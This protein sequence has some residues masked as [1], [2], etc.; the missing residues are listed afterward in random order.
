MLASHLARCADCRAFEESV[1][2]FTQEIRSAPLQSPQQPIVVRRTR[3]VSLTA[4]QIGVAATLAIAVL[5]VVSQ[6]RVPESPSPAADGRP[7]TTNLFK[8]SWQP[9]RELAQID[10]AV[11]APGT[12]RPGPL[13]AI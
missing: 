1:R 2:D 6:L 11:R 13:P 10:A 8:T 9:E 5:G 4:A 3:R 7:A 12:Q